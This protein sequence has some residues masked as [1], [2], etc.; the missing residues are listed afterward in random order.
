VAYVNGE[1]SRLFPGTVSRGDAGDVA[2]ALFAADDEV[3]LEAFCAMA[4]AGGVDYRRELPATAGRPSLE[5]KVSAL[6]VRGGVYGLLFVVTD[7]TL[8]KRM[9]KAERSLE[10]SSAVSIMA[11]GLAHEIRNP[12]ASVRGAIQEIG[13]AF[14]DGSQN[15]L[16]ADIVI[17]ESD[18][19]DGIIE[20]FLDFSREGVLRIA[21]RRLGGMLRNVQAML[22]QGNGGDALDIAVGVADDPEVECDADRIMQVFVNLGLNAAQAVPPAGGKIDISLLGEER[23]GVPGVLV[24]FRDNGPGLADEVIERMFEPF[25]TGKPGG[26]GMGLPLSRKEVLRHGGDI[27]ADS[28]PDG[29]ACFRVWLPLRAERVR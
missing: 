25:F 16:L 4:A 28:A 19:L 6:R 23:N 10:R 9:E 27:D 24:V 3:G 7:L 26:T 13:T 15:R 29:G 1:F 18:R 14:P 2:A 12:L 22:R 11:A 17:S 8:R 5:V 21:P 20:R